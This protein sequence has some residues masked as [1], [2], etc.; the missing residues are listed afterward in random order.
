MWEK[1]AKN[2]TQFLLFSKKTFSSEYSGF[3]PQTTCAALNTEAVQPNTW[4]RKAFNSGA[5]D[6]N[7]CSW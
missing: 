3:P 5:S 4:K 7:I 2:L 1:T 6:T